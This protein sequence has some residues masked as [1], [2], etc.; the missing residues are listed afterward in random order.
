MSEHNPDTAAYVA[1]IKELEAECAA[2]G[3]ELSILKAGLDAVVE[4]RIER[5]VAEAL[6]WLRLW[7]DPLSDS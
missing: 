1:R 3:E 7:P 2:L 5:V 4:T 6:Y